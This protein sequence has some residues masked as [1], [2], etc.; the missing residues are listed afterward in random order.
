MRKSI[1]IKTRVYYTILVID[2]QTSNTQKGVKTMTRD[3]IKL[4]YDYDSEELINVL[5]DEEVYYVMQTLEETEKYVMYEIDQLQNAIKSLK[6]EYW[7]CTSSKILEV[8]KDDI[9]YCTLNGVEL[10][11]INR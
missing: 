11:I 5:H 1:V 10:T 8:Y 6:G 7:D 3:E 9:T 4:Y 2:K